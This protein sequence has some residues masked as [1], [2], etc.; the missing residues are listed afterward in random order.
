M[1]GARGEVGR[2]E[3]LNDYHVPPAPVEPGVLLVD[4]DLPEAHRAQQGAAR[5]VLR[6]DPGDELPEARRFCRL[7]QGPERQTPRPTPPVV[8]LHIDGELGNPP[9]VLP[10]RYAN[11]AAK[12]TILP[13]SSTTTTG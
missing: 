12:A 1:P 8:P 11:V 10:G 9:V 3:A 2:D 4:P 13:S 5:G 6:E 7:D